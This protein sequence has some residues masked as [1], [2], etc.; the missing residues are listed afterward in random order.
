MSEKRAREV[1]KMVREWCDETEH[2]LNKGQLWSAYKAFNS[3]QSCARSGRDALSMS[4]FKAMQD[5]GHLISIR[6]AKGKHK[7]WAV[8]EE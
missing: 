6:D 3:M 5:Y 2:R 4:T 7:E 8:L 1:L